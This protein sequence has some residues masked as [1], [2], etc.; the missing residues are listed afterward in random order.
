MKVEGQ[1]TLERFRKALTRFE[2]ALRLPVGEGANLDGTIQRFEFTFELAW[3]CAKR[4]L[5]AEGI[6]ARSPRHVIKECYAQNWID[7][8]ATWVDMMH[9]RNRTSHTYVEAIALEVYQR[10]GDYA[11]L[12]RRL[13]ETIPEVSE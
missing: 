4:V 13:S 2:E 3:K 10:L 6:D 12:L 7:D 9:D 1:E 8:E 5:A 11:K